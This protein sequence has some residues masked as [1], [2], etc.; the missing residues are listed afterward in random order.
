MIQILEWLCRWKCI[1][2]V[3]CSVLPLTEPSDPC[4][5]AERS[6]PVVAHP[7]RKPR[8]NEVGPYNSAIL[9]ITSGKRLYS[10]VCRSRSYDHQPEISYRRTGGQ[11]CCGFCSISRMF[12]MKP[13]CVRGMSSS[14]VL[15]LG[16]NILS[17]SPCGHVRQDVSYNMLLT[18]SISRAMGSPFCT[19]SALF[20]AA[21][22]RSCT[23]GAS[24]T[25]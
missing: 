24:I 13:N 2:A 8:K 23:P 1:T 9:I 17:H 10:C 6:S 19:G 18:Q 14:P 7:L 11:D 20:R 15:T 5:E 25:V 12:S 4:R 16:G 3:I 22:C 21:A